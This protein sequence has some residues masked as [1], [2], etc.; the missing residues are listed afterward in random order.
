[1]RIWLTLSSSAR[2]AGS[3]FTSTSMPF[4][5]RNLR[6]RESRARYFLGL[7]Q[8]MPMVN[9]PTPTV[10]IAVHFTN[11]SASISPTSPATAC[12]ASFQRLAMSSLPR[13]LAYGNHQLWKLL[14]TG[15]PS[16]SVGRLLASPK[17]RFI[18]F[19]IA[20][21]FSSVSPRLKSA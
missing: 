18:S 17:N 1:M 9:L 3:S 10:P 4:F 15:M 2:Y 8:N 16:K 21:R 13:S 7:S 12:S 6:F 11:R 5:L 14:A 20:T 19:R